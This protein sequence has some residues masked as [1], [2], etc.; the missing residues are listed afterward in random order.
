MKNGARIYALYKFG[1]MWR[2]VAPRLD[3][4]DQGGLACLEFGSRQPASK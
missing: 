4:L 3:E 1:E 2:C